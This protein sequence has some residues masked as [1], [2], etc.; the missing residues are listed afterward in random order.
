MGVW[1]KLFSK[2]WRTPRTPSLGE[3]IKEFLTVIEANPDI[4]SMET[5]EWYR[6]R[7]GQ[8]AQWAQETKEASPFTRQ[9]FRKYV[10]YL[11]QRNLSPYTLRGHINILRRFGRWLAEEGYA[12]ENPAAGLRPPRMPK[13]TRK[14]AIASEDIERMLKAAK[15][16]GFRNYVLLLFLRATGARAA[17]VVKLRW[18][19]VNLDER[20][21]WVKGKGG[22]VRKVFFKEGVARILAE[23]RETVSHSPDD[24]V[25]PKYRGDGPLTVRGLQALLWRLAQKAKVKGPFRPHAWRHAFGRDA[26]LNGC[27]TLTLQKLMGHSSPRVTAEYVELAD[28]QLAKAYDEYAPEIKVE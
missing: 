6:R 12:L 21:A 8:F 13:E 23:Y 10:A 25:W 15:E 18:K 20:Y 1:S 3:I 26:V 11:K 27:P 16:S 9:A 22:K 17:E 24:P 2:L 7:L 28:E 19:D 14:K 4:K 5:I